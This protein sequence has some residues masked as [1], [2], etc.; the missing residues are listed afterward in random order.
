M[1]DFSG[2]VLGCEDD[3]LKRD[4]GEKRRGDA[5]RAIAVSPRLQVSEWHL[6]DG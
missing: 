5:E 4:A 3:E 2:R 6:I 1:K